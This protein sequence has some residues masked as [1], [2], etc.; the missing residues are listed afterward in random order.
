[1]E[2]TVLG[3]VTISGSKLRLESNSLQRA[4]SLRKLVEKALEPL[5]RHRGRDHADPAARLGKGSPGMGGRPARA[6]SSQPEI[7]PDEMNRLVLEF[8]AKHY[9]GWADDPLPALKGKT[10]REAVRT[11]AGREQVDLLLRE[12][13]NGEARMPAGQRYDFS[14]LR[15]E[16][17]LEE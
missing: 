5:V 7:P 1:M 2:S 10:A 9:A 11:N 4:D 12:F 16:L 3:T 14:G 17:G 13:E 6:P 15:S 8:K